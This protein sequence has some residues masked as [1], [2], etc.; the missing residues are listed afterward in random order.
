MKTLTSV[1]IVMEVPTTVASF[2]R[3]NASLPLQNNPNAFVFIMN[4]PS[5]IIFCICLFSS[6][7]KMF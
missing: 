7:E 5:N 1:T 3:I 2:Y 6:K 4:L